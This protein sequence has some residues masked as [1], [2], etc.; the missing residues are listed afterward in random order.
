MPLRTLTESVDRLEQEGHALRDEMTNLRRE[1][2]R[3]NRRFGWFLGALAV[4]L[5]CIGVAAFQVTLDNRRAIQDNNRKFCDLTAQSARSDPP[6]STP[7]G[8]ALQQSA[9]RLYRDLGCTNPL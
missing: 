4:A 7:R 9:L 3:E 5:V 8:A 2:E 6:P 1:K